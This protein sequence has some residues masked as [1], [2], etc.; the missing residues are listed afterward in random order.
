MGLGALWLVF[1]NGFPIGDDY[2]NQIIAYEAFK[3][4]V[5][6][7]ELYPRW[8]HNINHGF[9]GAN[10]F[11]YPPLIYYVSYFI[12]IVGL[13]QFDTLHVLILNVS[14]FLILSGITCYFWLSSFCSR[15]ASVVGAL[16]Y[17]IA[18]YHLFIDVYER[19]NVA[20]FAAFAWIPLLFLLS[21]RQPFPKYVLG[22]LLAL[23]YALF[24][25]T[26]LPSAVFVTPF[27]VFAKGCSILTA[28]ERSIEKISTFGV[29][30]FC[31]FLGGCLAGIYLYPALTL[32]DSVRSQV[33][34]SRPFYDYKQWFLWWPSSSWPPLFK[35]Y[36]V[37]LFAIASFQFFVP[38]ALF[39]Y[40]FLNSDESRVKDGL[41]FML[42]AGFCFFLMT[43]FSHFVW[44]LFEP[45]QKIQ[46][47][48]RLLMLS[49]F[50]FVSLIA[51]FI[52]MPPSGRQNDRFVSFFRLCLIS[53]A[54]FALSLFTFNFVRLSWHPDS[55]FFEYRIKHKILT[56]EF[57]PKNKEMTVT[58]HDF[59]EK[60]PAYP[61]WRF[62]GPLAEVTIMKNLPR[63]MVF[64]V[65]S[66]DQ[67]VF[68]LRQFH[69]IGW[70][71][72]ITF[73]DGN[74][75]DL[76][77]SPLEPYGQISVNLPP[78]AYT[79]SFFIPAL[80]QEQVG[81]LISLSGL[82]AWLFLFLYSCFKVR[83]GKHT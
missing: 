67:T 80:P 28:H 48:F 42:S 69:F 65:N 73:E 63:Q 24:L 52:S 15:Y 66:P 74:H 18:P 34:W 1:F 64:R 19:N 35:N 72:Q 26:H 21:L 60:T 17:M 68:I 33:L 10:L 30:L 32:L 36:G 8:L 61:L 22:I 7:G 56:G 50:F 57:I 9:G 75:N 77:I 55:A 53:S 54:F 13:Q 49:D 71:S 47:P 11:F 16:L 59:V 29:F 40:F 14:F 46:F 2:K 4:Q 62:D 27:L 79:L 43:P 38:L 23:V 31:L 83:M 81:A 37:L 12:D 20:E 6:A 76:V 45:L 78:G 51:F 70:R 3:E 41:P 5:Q 82:V 58:I 39:V 25:V 44:V